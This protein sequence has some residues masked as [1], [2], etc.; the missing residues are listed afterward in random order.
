[1]SR[2]AF[3]DYSNNYQVPGSRESELAKPVDLPTKVRR[4]KRAEKN[5][6]GGP[7][8]DATEGAAGGENYA[9]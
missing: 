5:S 1:M 7:L 9:L 8:E 4:A 3:H 2:A 6:P